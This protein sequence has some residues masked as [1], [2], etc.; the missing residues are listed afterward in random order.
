MP[1]LTRNALIAA[2]LC[3]ALSGCD[4]DSAEPAQD[5]PELSDAKPAL[6]GTIDDSHAGE[7]LP[8]L[9]VRQANGTVLNLGASQGEPLLVNLW[10]TWCAPCIVEMPML[11]ELAQDMN[12][13][14]RVLTVS[15]DL[16]GAE[17]VEPFFAER[18]FAMLEPWLDPDTTLSTAIGGDVM[19]TT[20]LYDASGREMWRVVGDYDWSSAEAREAI[21]TALTE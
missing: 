7:L 9:E 4:R 11:D 8:T 3:L 18:N 19:P 12:G 16:Q 5:S 10:A 17:A 14:L 6:A 20:V 2:G 1:E 13:K 21:A 15:Q